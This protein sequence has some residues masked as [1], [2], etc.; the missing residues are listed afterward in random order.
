MRPLH[1]GTK[2]G[3]VELAFGSGPGTPAAK[4]DDDVTLS[5][6]KARFLALESLQQRLQ[7]KIYESYL[8]RQVQVLAERRDPAR[9][10]Q[11]LSDAEL[12]KPAFEST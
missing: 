8:G 2:S 5:E 7:Q 3:V 10:A 11:A 4:L 1:A 6:K 9:V 12:M